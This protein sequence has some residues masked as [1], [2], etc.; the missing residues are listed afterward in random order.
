MCVSMIYVKILSKPHALTVKFC[1]LLR[2]LSLLQ[3]RIFLES[4]LKLYSSPKKTN[5]QRKKWYN[6]FSCLKATLLTFPKKKSLDS[7]WTKIETLGFSWQ[8]SNITRIRWLGFE[9]LTKMSYATYFWVISGRITI[10]NEAWS[11]SIRKFADT[12]NYS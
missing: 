10:F 11:Q 8:K 4:Y 1:C 12:V 9:N 7:N 2:C 5:Y 3:W 6:N